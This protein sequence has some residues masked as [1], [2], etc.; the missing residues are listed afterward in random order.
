MSL[1]LDALKKSAQDRE[2][3]PDDEPSRPFSAT[4]GATPKRR[5]WPYLVASTL[6]T[7]GAIAGGV[8]WF[9]G[10]LSPLPDE[11]FPKVQA[12]LELPTKAKEPVL[13]APVPKLPAPEIAKPEPAPVIVKE[14]IEEDE[15]EPSPD[16]IDL[17]PVKKLPE[18][19]KPEIAPEAPTEITVAEEPEK[20]SEPEQ[21]V[22]AAPE[23]EP[24]PVENPKL[25]VKPAPEPMPEPEPSVPAAL[26]PE[27][28]P[29]EKPKLEAK[30]E[31][32]PDPKPEPN[33]VKTVAPLPVPEPPSPPIKPMKKITPLEK[34][35]AEPPVIALKKPIIV[36]L[37]VPKP[38][39]KP[40]PK[41]KAP[42]PRQAQKHNDKG[43][44]FEQEG[45]FEKAIE[46]YT[47]AIIIKPEMV[48]AYIGRAW[49]HLSRGNYTKAIRNYGQAIRLK[50]SSADAYFG[51]GWAHEKAGDANQA[52]RDYSEAIRLGKNSSQAYFSRGILQFYR[53]STGMAADDFSAVLQ[54]GSKQ[55]RPYALIWMYLSQARSGIDGRESLRT[56]GANMDLT[57][58]PG[59]LVS[60]YLGD[61][62]SDRVLS[63]AQSPNPKTQRENECV[64]NFFLGQD[65]LVRGDKA[66]AADYFRKTIATGVTSYRQYTAAEEELR[67]L[68]LLKK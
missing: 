59:I 15:A 39:A 34:P 52:I 62:T 51:R 61:V 58:W 32:K 55:L 53:N 47:Q 67:R 50:P 10:T 31:P 65:R 60:Y 23:P 29:V 2:E 24:T 54:Q 7:G 37:P 9:K 3:N 33:A 27:P 11:K 1:I 35:L 49:S 5:V 6:L 38:K 4:E 63:A 25:E 40:K 57:T 46:E 18:I 68:G 56:Y 28:A 44:A 66:G 13:K 43:R 20:K 41:P 64:A 30:P 48:K 45:L 14:T 12:A 17:E 36:P 16:K 42:D 8:F 21:S 26:E 19:A 22:L